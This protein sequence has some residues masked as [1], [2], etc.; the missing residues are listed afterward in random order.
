MSSLSIIEEQI[1]HRKPVR[2]K[3]AIVGN[4]LMSR[5][6]SKSLRRFAHSPLLYDLRCSGP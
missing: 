2:A 1:K 4:S 5:S 6:L 3:K